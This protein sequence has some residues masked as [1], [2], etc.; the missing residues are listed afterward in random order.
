VPLAQFYSH[1]QGFFHGAGDSQG[2]DQA[3]IPDS[4][5]A[6][7]DWKQLLGQVTVPWEHPGHPAAMPVI[8]RGCVQGSFS[9][10]S[11]AAFPVPFPP[12]WLTSAP[13]LLELMSCQAAEL[14]HLTGDSSVNNTHG[15]LCVLGTSNFR[16]PQQAA[17]GIR[18]LLMLGF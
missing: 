12:L 15:L 4:F 7:L 9:L 6:H 16:H 14:T 8:P 1:V 18:F 5:L 2:Q 10:P 3:V 13:D 17:F 11:F